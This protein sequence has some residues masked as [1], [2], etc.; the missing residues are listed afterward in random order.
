MQH[1]ST[2]QAELAAFLKNEGRTI[3]QFAGIS[4][5]NSGTLSSIINGNRPIAMQQLDRITAG[6]GLPE[7]TFYELY[8]DE[9]VV[10]STPDWR[11]LGPFLQRCAELD[12]L[13]CIRQ[14]VQII[15]DNITYAPLLFDT[16]EE[17][18]SQ[19]KLQAAALLYEG[20]ADSEKYQHSERLALCQYR[21]FTIRTGQSPE[22]D[23]RAAT[24]FEY[25]VERL[26]EAD[27]LG[28]LQ[29][30]AGIYFSLGHLEKAGL[31]AEQ[32]YH[33][34]SIQYGIRYHRT[35]KQKEL[36]EPPEPFCFYILYAY[37]LQSKVYEEAG[38]YGQAM[39]YVGKYTDM[40]WIVETSGEV[41]E[42]K[43]QF[44]RRGAV[45]ACLYRL[46]SGEQD[47]LA[48]YEKY[49]GSEELGLIAGLLHAVQAVNRFHWEADGLIG[50]FQPQLAQVQ[51]AFGQGTPGPDPEGT[52]NQGVDSLEKF[53]E[54]LYE[55]AVYYSHSDRVEQALQALFQSLEASAALGSVACVIR[56]VRLFEQ[57]RPLASAP[58]Q[59]RYKLLINKVQVAHVE[60]TVNTQD[61]L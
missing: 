36:R 16:A 47:R 58:D 30:L 49:I 2:I 59:E 33:K 44:R 34:A 5:V 23:F 57:L 61:R 26:E 1:K 48:E 41:Q 12:K 60:K 7:G 43:E 24:R 31:L 22:A 35:R 3:N 14:V 27:Q 46:M 37:W 29:Q 54:L 25:F 19:G 50:R 21:L 42:I 10:H 6:M 39:E 11:R 51:A 45:S 53:P 13:E 55:L 20:V 9:C 32:L 56:C 15:M 52:D 28:A 38:D 8:I 18:Y 4:G 40:G 17:F